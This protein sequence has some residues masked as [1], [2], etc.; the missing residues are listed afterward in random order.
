MKSK[1]GSSLLLALLITLFAAGVLLIMIPI[2]YC[3]E[4]YD[5]FERYFGMKAPSLGSLKDPVIREMTK[6]YVA[7]KLRVLSN[8]C[9]ARKPIMSALS[10]P[11]PANEAKDLQSRI[12][13]YENSRRITE[14]ACQ[15]FANAD[16]FAKKYKLK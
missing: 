13:A 15:Y 12:E 3:V 5:G 4:Y 16:E 11:S 8:D 1:R 9:E 2:A 7:Q 10:K 14:A 6:P